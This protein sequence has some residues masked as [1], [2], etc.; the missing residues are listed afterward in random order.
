MKLEYFYNY[1]M[2]NKTFIIPICFV[3]IFISAAIIA[4]YFST[5]QKVKRIL[6]KLPNKRIISLKSNDFV[7]VTGIA[8]TIKEPLSA[9]LSERKCVFYKIKIEQETGDEDSSSWK[10]LIDEERYQ[11]FL[12]E[13]NGEFLLV[14]LKQYPKN[15]L[16]HLVIDKKTSS[17]T[18]KDPSTKFKA[19][20]NQYNIKSTGFLGFNKQ[21]RYTESIIEIGKK[22]TVAGIANHTSIN[23]KIE[24]YN[25]SKIVELKSSNQQKLI[26]TD[27]KNIKSKRRI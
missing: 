2:D 5:K 16:C 22:I 20:L 3:I 7:K 10:T 15:F 13:Q 19:I 4:W 8:K 14:K 11:E 27:L 18:F 17:R 25:Y 1:F 23:Q 12:L 26:I 24:G 21:L 6:S 9:P